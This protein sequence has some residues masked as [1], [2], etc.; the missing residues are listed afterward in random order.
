MINYVKEYRVR[1]GLTQSQL[2]EK[3]GVSR[4]AI[5]NIERRLSVPKIDLALRIYY[6]LYVRLQCQFFK[7]FPMIDVLIEI[8]GLYDD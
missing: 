5:S 7:I 3:C 8:G 1:A 4:V 2:A 6:V